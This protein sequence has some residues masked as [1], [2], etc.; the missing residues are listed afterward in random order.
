RPARPRALAGWRGPELAPVR[1][2][3]RAAAT[4]PGKLSR[5]AGRYWLGYSPGRYRLPMAGTTTVGVNLGK[6]WAAISRPI[7]VASPAATSATQH[8]P[9]PA[10]VSRAPN[11]P[12]RRCIAATSSSIAG[13][14]TA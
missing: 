4:G 11:T 2:Q 8:P 1:P 3:V 13:S 6:L 14:D 5:P 7:A 10:P 12:G 9:K